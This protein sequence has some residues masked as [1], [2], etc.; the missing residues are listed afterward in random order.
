MVA[1]AVSRDVP[2]YPKETTPLLAVDAQI[3]Q[4]R[5][6][7]ARAKPARANSAPGK[8]TYVY[9]VTNG[10]HGSFILTKMDV[11]PKLQGAFIRNVNQELMG[12]NALEGGERAKNQGVSLSL[13]QSTHGKSKTFDIL[14]WLRWARGRLGL[15]PDEKPIKVT[16]V[17]FILYL[18]LSIRRAPDILEELA[19]ANFNARVDDATGGLASLAACDQTNGALNTAH[20]AGEA[21]ADGAIADTSVTAGGAGRPPQKPAFSAS[22]SEVRLIPS[23]NQVEPPTPDDH[24]AFTGF[25]VTDAAGP[26]GHPHASLAAG[27]LCSDSPPTGGIHAPGITAEAASAADA[28]AGIET[29]RDAECVETTSFAL[30]VRTGAF[31]EDHQVV[32]SEAEYDALHQKLDAMTDRGRAREIMK[33]FSCRP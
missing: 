21:P 20:P 19:N 14:V 13:F 32:L 6:Q 31:P 2:T 3:E 25:V 11:C 24:G 12:V 16:F 18:P 29:L 22:N 28:L 8:T 1:K 9:V 27:K 4:T 26:E 17:V 15:N 30:A 5:L 10:G 23:R 7:T 33:N